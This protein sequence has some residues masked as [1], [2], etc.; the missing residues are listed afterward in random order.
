MAVI[1]GAVIGWCC[2]HWDC[3]QQ[4]VLSISVVLIRALIHYGFYDWGVY[5]LEAGT[6]VFLSHEAVI[7]S[8]C[9]QFGLY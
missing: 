8:D 6:R 2:N 3:N 7:T 5:S 1:A 9:N 4:V